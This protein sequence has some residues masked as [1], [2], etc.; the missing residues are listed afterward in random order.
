[1]RCVMSATIAVGDAV[2]LSNVVDDYENAEGVVIE[3][4]VLPVSGQTAYVVQVGDATVEVV[5]FEVSYVRKAAGGAW[6][7]PHF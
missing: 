3:R 6:Q 4:N 1:M 2:R 5:D 7:S